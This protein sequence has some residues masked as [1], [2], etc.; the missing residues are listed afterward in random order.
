VTGS[1]GPPAASTAQLA[2]R[3][4]GET[5]VLAVS[6]EAPDGDALG[7]LSAFMLVCERLSI[8]CTA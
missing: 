7:C 2:E 8:E 3:L 1:A 6:H 4:Q 5:S